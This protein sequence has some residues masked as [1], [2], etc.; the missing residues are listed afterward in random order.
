MVFRKVRVVGRRELETQ[1]CPRFVVIETE[2][3]KCGH[4]VHNESVDESVK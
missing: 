3:S 2:G 1:M 4:V